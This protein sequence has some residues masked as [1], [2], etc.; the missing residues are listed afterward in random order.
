MKAPAGTATVLAALLV[1]VTAGT[2]VTA[3]SPSPASLTWP[4]LT[5]E[6]WILYNGPVE[7]VGSGIRLV[8]T[9][10]TDDHAAFAGL[11]SGEQWHPDWS[12]DGLSIAF[13]ADDTD[14]TRDVWMGPADGSRAERIY[15]LHR[16]L[17]LER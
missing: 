6:S 8:R 4:L 16:P 13:S 17:R 3:T 7:D 9:D 12:P 2:P 5:G 15:R 1:M 10:G 11:T 14:G